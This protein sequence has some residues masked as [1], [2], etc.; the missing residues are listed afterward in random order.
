MSST[1]KARIISANRITIPDEEVEA[2][3]LKQ[4][5]LVEVEV[6]KVVPLREVPAQ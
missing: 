3:G 2:Q 4:G 6:K 5:D 1:F